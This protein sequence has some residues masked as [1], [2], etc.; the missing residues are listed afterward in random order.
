M[1][2]NAIRYIKTILC[3]FKPSSVIRDQPI[4][5]KKKGRRRINRR[6]W[7]RLIWI[8]SLFY[9]YTRHTSART[10]QCSKIRKKYVSLKGSN[11]FLK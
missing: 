8:Y 1:P 9:T 2:N 11:C 6:A 3:W 5:P 10:S 7:A 4:V